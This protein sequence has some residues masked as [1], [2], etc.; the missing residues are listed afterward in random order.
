MIWW[1]EMAGLMVSIMDI[2]VIG[3]GIGDGIGKG[4]G[5]GICVAG[6]GINYREG[7]D[8]GI[9]IARVTVCQHDCCKGKGVIVVRARDY[10]CEREGLII[11]RA[12][13]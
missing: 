7:M 3:N 2:G 10:Y 4:G 6:R 12:A 11:A 8:E 5:V 1:D 13:A 9:I